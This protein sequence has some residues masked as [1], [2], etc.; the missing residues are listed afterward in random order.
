MSALQFEALGDARAAYET[1]DEMLTNQEIGGLAIAS[2][3]R[4]KRDSLRAI[5]PVNDAI[6]NASE[7]QPGTLPL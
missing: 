2:Q 1:L 7:L 3:A 5:L 4:E 6:E